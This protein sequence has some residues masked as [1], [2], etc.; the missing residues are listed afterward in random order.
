VVAK[1]FVTARDALSMVVNPSN[2]I[3]ELTLQQLADIYLGKTTNWKQLGGPDK[4]IVANGRESSSGTFVFFQEHVLKKKPYAATV[5]QNASTNAIVEN[6]SQDAGAIGYVGL[7]YVNDKVKSLGIKKDAGSPAVAA[8]VANVLNS[9]YPLSRPLFE[10]TAGE[11]T[12]ATKTWIDWVMGPDG[13]K[14]VE[15]LGFVPIK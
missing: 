10:Y 3:K 7:G 4:N 9:T 1:Y 6:V 2:P 15:K 5:L 11:P 13:Q 12:G 14:I 8:S